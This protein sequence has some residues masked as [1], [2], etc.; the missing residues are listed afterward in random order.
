[1]AMH[2][3]VNLQDRGSS[4]L[5]PAKYKYI[6]CYNCSGYG[7]CTDEVQNHIDIVSR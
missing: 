7:G 6:T 3:A 5:S 2:Q 4:P 1:M